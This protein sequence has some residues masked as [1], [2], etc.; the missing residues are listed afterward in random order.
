MPHFV[1]TLIYLSQIYSY[2]IRGDRSPL[3]YSILFCYLMLNIP[4]HNSY[5]WIISQF[6][7]IARRDIIIAKYLTIYN[8]IN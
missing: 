8:L 2:Y 6:I 7:S 1:A 5:G 4:F 3:P